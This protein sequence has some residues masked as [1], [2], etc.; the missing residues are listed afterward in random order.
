MGD[1]DPLQNEHGYDEYDTGRL[2]GDRAVPANMSLRPADSYHIETYN[3]IASVVVFNDRVIV[4]DKSG[5]VMV[6]DRFNGQ[7]RVA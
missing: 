7:L 3:E 6:V 4:I 2:G 1:H 5:N